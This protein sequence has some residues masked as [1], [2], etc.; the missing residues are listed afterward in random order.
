MSAP[1]P[2][3]TPSPAPPEVEDGSPERSTPLVD[4]VM[5]DDDD[6]LILH[7][8]STSKL[9]TTT[10]GVANLNGLAPVDRFSPVS[11]ASLDPAS[12]GPIQDLS[13]FSEESVLPVDDMDEDEVAVEEMRNLKDL[14][15]GEIA[16]VRAER[17]QRPRSAQ[18]TSP[19]PRKP[20]KKKRRKK[21]EEEE[22]SR[23][24]YHDLPRYDVRNLINKRRS[25]RERTD[26]PPRR[27]RHRSYG[28]S[29]TRS[30]TRSRSISRSR[31][32]S[33]SRSRSR[34]ISPRRK[35]RAKSTRLKAKRTKERTVT[36]A[37]KETVRSP[38]KGSNKST[39][40]TAKK[41]KQR[42]K[43]P[44]PVKKKHRRVRHS[45][46][47]EPHVSFSKTD[48]P[49]KSKKAPKRAP[50]AVS[51]TPSSTVA[52]EVFASGDNILVSVN[53][54]PNS[55][56][57]N[58]D[59]SSKSR[60]AGVAA[61]APTEL[62]N[63]KPAAVI[64]IM[65]SPYL[66]IESSPKE[67]IDLASG[68]ED[69]PT[70]PEPVQSQQ[71]IASNIVTTTSALSEGPSSS[72][73]AVTSTSSASES[74][75]FPTVSSAG[76]SSSASVTVVTNNGLPKGP[77]TP[78]SHEEEAIDF[79]LGPQTPQ[80]DMS[81]SYDPCNP[82]ESPDVAFGSD[83]GDSPMNLSAFDMDNSSSS[84]KRLNNSGISSALDIPFLTDRVT[85]EKPTQNGNTSLSSEVP[86]DIAVDSPSS[87]Q[88]SDLSDLFE[89]PS[90]FSSA[91]KKTPTK[92]A[93]GNNTLLSKPARSKAKKPNKSVQMRLVDDKLRIIDDVPTSA[94]EM[95]VKEKFLKKVQRQE[96][97]VDE[98]KSVLKPFYNKKK[99]SK[100][101][102]KE[103][104]RKC[105]P[106]VCHS[107]NGAINTMKI[108]KLVNGYVKKYHHVEKHQS[109][110]S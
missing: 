106:K 37:P 76:A 95:A 13:S 31:S 35:K 20:P 68:D 108:Q 67:T 18:E 21:A 72:Q 23:R 6:E 80:S 30:R 4:E 90:L 33:P 14:E 17:R 110:V 102:Y 5:E 109:K 29:L 34:S 42:D 56:S 98:I 91:K 48:R 66:V 1:E 82:T 15:D 55:A 92:S 41:K 39:A 43:S 65:S 89:P 57:T 83:N 19:R 11:N 60:S 87:P 96:R 9:T 94:V 61:N 70:T 79:A 53:F 100:T 101:S 86:M 24:R 84:G 49:K 32:R 28:R 73:A 74:G 75:P 88:G 62:A 38:K 26:S 54:G 97:I 47:E 52:K 10:V 27:S 77:C 36:A 46:G 85:S 25:G 8:Q 12:P 71:P 45:S 105:V 50:T 107:K 58:G 44:E 2:S 81:E 22:L 16:V 103:I 69:E 64:D 7:D 104:M 51:G 40:K 63:Q 3:A 59:S 78:P 99:I 93:K